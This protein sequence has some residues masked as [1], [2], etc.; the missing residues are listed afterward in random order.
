MHLKAFAVTL[1]C[2]TTLAVVPALAQTKVT[3]QGITPTEIVIGTAERATL[4]RAPHH[5]G[6]GAASGA[7]NDQHQR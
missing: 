5:N 1:A 2:T 4:V 7:S 6:I 3:N